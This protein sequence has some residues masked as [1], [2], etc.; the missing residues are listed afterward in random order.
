MGNRTR[1][2][3]DV[4]RDCGTR[5]GMGW[6]VGRMERP[7]GP[8]SSRCHPCF[9]A[10]A[11]A[12]YRKQ[13]P[14]S[15]CSVCGSPFRRTNHGTRCLNC[16]TLKCKWCGSPFMKEGGASKECCSRACAR[17]SAAHAGRSTV[18]PWASCLTCRSWF[19]ARRGKV[20]HC[21]PHVE[22][23][24]ACGASAGPRRRF[25]ADCSA[26]RRKAA[27]KSPEARR[28]RKRADRARKRNAVSEPYRS[29]DVFIRD[30]WRCQ[31][32]GKR[33]SPSYS[34]HDLRSPVVDHIIPL[35]RGGHDTLDNV[36]CAHLICNSRKGDGVFGAGE[37]LRLVAV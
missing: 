7:W 37:Q 26:R 32:C 22:R 18:I 31:L 8:H 2:P 3:T 13:H 27:K 36:Q 16:R 35:A 25:C 12:K 24:C 5:D 19:V 10:Y 23:T 28:R 15:P 20:I 34:H 21:R 33:T 4:C 6:W 14:P 29:V 11:R 9:L 1:I 17:R 30:G